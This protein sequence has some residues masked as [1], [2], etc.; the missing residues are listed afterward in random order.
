M[1]LCILSE[2]CDGCRK[3]CTWCCT[4]NFP[5][6]WELVSLI[7]GVGAHGYNKEKLS[8][9]EKQLAARQERVV[10]CSPQASPEAWVEFHVAIL[11]ARND[12]KVLE[13]LAP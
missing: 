6:P 13:D 9:N 7:E 10:S 8:F 5:V 11:V 12:A 3:D 4:E 2:V 1:V